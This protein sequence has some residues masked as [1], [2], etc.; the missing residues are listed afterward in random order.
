MSDSQPA[1]PIEQL[2]LL[3]GSVD[4]IEVAGKAVDVGRRTTESLVTMLENLASTVDN[5]NR[6]T[7]RVNALL[8]EIEEPLRR[9]MPQVG[10]AMNA[11]ANLGDV[12]T[13]LSDLSRRLGPLTSIAENAGNLFGLRTNKSTDQQNPA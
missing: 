6:T 7:T 8:D 12:A 1:N 10:A 3:L 9:I 5:M 4:P 2:L 13:S 11:L